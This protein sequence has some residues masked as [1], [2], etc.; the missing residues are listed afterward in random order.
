MYT[1]LISD[2][3]IGPEFPHQSIPNCDSTT[4]AHVMI[5][6]AEKIQSVQPNQEL[7]NLPKIKLI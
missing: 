5:N 4:V 2:I 3:D 1:Y 6:N 7:K